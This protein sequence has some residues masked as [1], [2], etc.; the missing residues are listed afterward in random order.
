MF[1]PSIINQSPTGSNNPFVTWTFRCLTN[2]HFLNPH[3]HIYIEVSSPSQVDH[4][5]A[6]SGVCAHAIPIYYIEPI[7]V[8]I[9]CNVYKGLHCFAFSLFFSVG[10]PYCCFNISSL[11]RRMIMHFSRIRYLFITVCRMIYACIC[12]L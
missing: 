5:C 12:R 10:G 4:I 7:I 6:L 2:F 8:C 1:L 9:M 3:W 11:N